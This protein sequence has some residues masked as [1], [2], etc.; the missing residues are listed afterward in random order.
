MEVPEPHLN[1]D[2]DSFDEGN[3]GPAVGQVY[4]PDG[5][6]R[7][8]DV[9]DGE[10]DKNDLDESD[11]KYEEEENPLEV[12]PKEK[13]SKQGTSRTVTT[14]DKENEHD[15]EE[16]ALRLAALAIEEEKETDPVIIA[17][18]E[19]IEK[20]TPSTGLEIALSK[21]IERKETHIARLT[22]EIIKLRKFISKRKQTY[23]RKRKDDG[24]PTRALSA[25]NIFI[26]DRFAKLAKENEKA[27]KSEDKDAMMKRVPPASLVTS[28]GNAWKELSADEKKKYEER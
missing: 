8:T 13:K 14:D 15:E 25:Y 1:E 6:H 9:H 2:E 17:Q 22:A 28:T 23:K 10:N 18:I 11:E 27:L 21:A 24:A 16:E 20:T 3:Q 4:S 7:Q 12:L 5:S 26:Q 19:L